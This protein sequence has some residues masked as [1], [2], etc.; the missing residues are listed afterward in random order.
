MSGCFDSLFIKSSDESRAIKVT[1]IIA[2]TFI[3][4]I[5]MI[6]VKTPPASG[7]E[8]SIYNVYPWYLWV[9]V[10]TSIFLGQMI[11]LSGATASKKNDNYWVIGF[12]GILITNTILLFMPFI[13]GYTMYG[14]GDVLTHIG[15]IKDILNT[16]SIGTNN[17]YP[18]EH[19]L[20]AIMS[21]TTNISVGH[22]VNIIP[23]IL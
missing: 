16:A 4:L 8:I 14:R 10:I 9:F 1:A 23:P 20:T 22:A 18:I 17:Y 21:Y 15:Y 2:F 6:I 7:Y 13:R 19:I 5:L 12:L 11:L 3:V